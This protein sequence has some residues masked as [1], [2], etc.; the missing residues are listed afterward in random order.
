MFRLPIHYER[1][2]ETTFPVKQ[3]G[4]EVE[5]EDEVSWWDEYS[6]PLNWWK[7]AKGGY[8]TWE[9]DSLV[10]VAVPK[11][12]LDYLLQFYFAERYDL[13]TPIM[14]SPGLDSFG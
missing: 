2:Y 3:P 9:R 6:R 12:Y 5:R 13:E 7:A 14:E 8:G 4:S 10:K 1:A 11:Q